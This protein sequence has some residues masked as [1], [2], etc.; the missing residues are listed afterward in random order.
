ME[1]NFLPVDGRIDLQSVSRLARFLCSIG[2]QDF[3]SGVLVM[4]STVRHC[5][6][7]CCRISSSSGGVRI[8]C[9]CDCQSDRSLGPSA[10]LERG[11]LEVAIGSAFNMDVSALGCFPRRSAMIRCSSE[12]R[13]SYSLDFR[14]DF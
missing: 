11:A 1:E 10:W 3:F 7:H 14:M 9:R 4:R 12:L 8:R 6:M 13:I 2:A 5:H